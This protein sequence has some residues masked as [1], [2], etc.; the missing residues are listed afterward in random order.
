MFRKKSIPAADPDSPTTIIG[1]GA[2]LE[3]ARLTGQESVRI[4]GI[5]KGNIDI[6]GSLV[7]GDTGSITGNVTADYFL[8]AGEVNGNIKC[9]TQLHFASTAK[10]TGDV[11]ASSLI[12]DEGSRVSGRYMVGAERLPQ[13]LLEAKG[14]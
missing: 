1:K 12:V 7:L 8:V 3:A 10:T 9:H 5:F 4:D 6:E 11:H 2:Y 13:D 14:E